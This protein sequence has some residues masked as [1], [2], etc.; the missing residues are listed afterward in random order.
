M[1]SQGVLVL[2]AI[3]VVV[4]YVVITI[5]AND[6]A[7]RAKQDLSPEAILD[8]KPMAPSVEEILE[9]EDQTGEPLSNR[10]E[11]EQ[12][13]LI[14]TVASI[15]DPNEY[16]RL[17]ETLSTYDMEKYI[18]SEGP[19]YDI[20]YGYNVFVDKS[21]VP[22]VSDMYVYVNGLVKGSDPNNVDYIR[23]NG[24]GDEYMERMKSLMSHFN[25]L[26]MFG[27]EDTRFYML[28]W[29]THFAE[30][31]DGERMYVSPNGYE[32]KYTVLKKLQD[33]RESETAETL[34]AAGLEEMPSFEDRAEFDEWLTL[35][36]DLAVEGAVPMSA[37]IAA[38]ASDLTEDEAI[39]AARVQRLGFWLKACVQSLPV[40]FPTPKAVSENVVDVPAETIEET[41][42]VVLDSETA[43]AY[44]SR[45]APRNRR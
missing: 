42:S 43:E 22:F 2:I 4:V 14:D 19:C 12:G 32:C 1:S 20:Y 17:R 18:L 16:E 21:M 9:G 38:S 28:A 26:F 44:H 15:V 10:Q 6:A 8:R 35:H 5:K 27:K 39:R 29:L 7:R 30:V 37:S 40:M 33:H 36:P 31:T 3:I 45:R 23:W 24:L 41:P 13:G 34:K 11:V 25:E